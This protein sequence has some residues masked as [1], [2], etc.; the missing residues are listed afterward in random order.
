MKSCL[1]VG[2]SG[3]VGT[4]ISKYYLNNLFDKIHI[5]DLEKPGYSHES[6]SFTQGD[7]RE[8]ID[9]D[10]CDFKP[11]WIFNLAAIHREP[12][13]R[14]EEYFET[15]IKGAKHVCKYANAVNCKNIYFT[16]SISVYGPVHEA[17]DENS[18]TCPNSPYGSSKLAAEYIH[19]GWQKAGKD[20]RLLIVRPGVIYGPGDPGNIMRMI[21]AIRK[22][23]FAFPGNTNIKKSYAYIYGL[24]ES[25][26]FFI[27]KD[28]V[29]NIRYNYV[30]YPT[31]TIGEIANHVNEFFNKRTPIFSLPKWL[32]LPVAK[33]IQ[34]VLGDKNPIH[35]RRVEKASM[36]TNII[37]QVL[38]NHEFNFK[39][40]FKASLRDWMNK[41]SKDFE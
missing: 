9:P 12:G 22:G 35:P 4:H 14:P 16:S 25:I 32:L 33:I 28:G 26:K 30:E 40:D 5:L 1:L 24:L 41:K 38:I 31:E 13:H 34:S 17:T 7:V 15:N 39:Y 10:L 11:D 6:I 27:E 37:P 8:P 3:F 36:P 29:D 19:D 18:L 20:R 2:G 21:E 23:Y